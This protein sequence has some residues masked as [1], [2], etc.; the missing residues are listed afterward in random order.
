MPARQLA[1]RGGATQLTQRPDRE[2]LVE[3]LAREPGGAALVELVARGVG[4][5]HA[6][7]GSM[8]PPLSLVWKGRACGLLGCAGLGRSLYSWPPPDLM[9]VVMD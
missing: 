8:Q 2:A 3:E 9:F 6:G 1:P 7:K 4:Y 5:H